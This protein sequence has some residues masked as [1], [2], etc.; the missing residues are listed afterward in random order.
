MSQAADRLYQMTLPIIGEDN[1][2]TVFYPHGTSTRHAFMPV[3]NNEYDSVATIAQFFSL[4]ESLPP[5]EGL[6]INSEDFI[7]RVDTPAALHEMMDHLAQRLPEP[8]PA[9]PA[10]DPSADGQ[11]NEVPFWNLG[12]PSGSIEYAA[13]ILQG[14]VRFRLKCSD[15][16][17]WKA[18][19]DDDSTT[20]IPDIRE[21]ERAEQDLARCVAMLKDMSDLGD[22]DGLSINPAADDPSITVHNIPN[23][24]SML[25]AYAEDQGFALGTDF[26][27]KIESIEVAEQEIEEARQALEDDPSILYCLQ[28]YPYASEKDMLAD[29]SRLIIASA[30]GIFVS[31]HTTRDIIQAH[32]RENKPEPV[33]LSGATPTFGP[34]Q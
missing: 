7:L 18:E 34:M 31:P 12:S 15:D 29:V 4:L 6:R 25:E 26:L 11:E 21:G 14:I 16:I 1:F 23:F 27:R 22:W 20:F 10:N 17:F 2:S 28:S 24:C 19:S 3:E 32:G 9:R 30:A 33:I 13:A 5:V 8:E